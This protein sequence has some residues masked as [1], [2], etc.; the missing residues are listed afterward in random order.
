MGTQKKDDFSFE[1]LDH[2]KVLSKNEKGW[3]KE[4]NLIKWGDNAPKYDIRDW[5]EDHTKMGEGIT[6]T[7]DEVKAL[8]EVHI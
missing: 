8:I 1:I 2:I 5:N 6:L 3:S 4:L 7:K